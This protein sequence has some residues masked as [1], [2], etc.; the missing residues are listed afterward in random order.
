[1]AM[2][3]VTDD[4]ICGSISI[5][6][7]RNVRELLMI[8]A[9]NT[10]TQQCLDLSGFQKLTILKV[11]TTDKEMKYFK[12]CIHENHFLNMKSLI[13]KKN[14]YNKIAENSFEHSHGLEILDLSSNEFETI[15]ST[16][17][18]GLRSLKNLY[19]QQNL[20]KNI[21]FDLCNH[22]SKLKILWLQFNQIGKVDNNMI[23]TCKHLTEMN[24]GFNKKI[25]LEMR[26][27]I[28]NN[29]NNLI[30]KNMNGNIKNFTEENQSKN[31][32]FDK[33]END[34]NN[35]LTFTVI[36]MIFAGI[37]LIIVCFLARF[38]TFSKL[39]EKKESK[40]EKQEKKTIKNGPMNCG[41]KNQEF[42]YEEFPDNY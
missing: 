32:Y 40:S 42:F 12:W 22:L 25:N 27:Q 1:M 13:L 38:A 41:I 24:V 28:C 7:K 18:F 33:M 29:S 26:P 31:K 34:L 2:C 11:I 30:Q 21:D 14:F 17:F 4:D 6:E 19:L 15:D 10:K 37:L 23:R 5:M 35:V 39:I 9:L 16:T 8:S 36:L 20:I 3:T